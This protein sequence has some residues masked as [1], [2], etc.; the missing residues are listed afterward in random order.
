MAS[1]G[2]RSER[3][4]M[5]VP[6]I[7]KTDGTWAYL[8]LGPQGPQGIQ[9]IQ[10]PKGD[11][12]SIGPVGP[13][14]PPKAV[15][16][17]ALWGPAFPF[18]ETEVTQGLAG[19]G[20]GRCGSPGSA[21]SSQDLDQVAVLPGR[22]H[23]RCVGN[24][25]VQVR[26]LQRRHLPARCVPAPWSPADRRHQRGHDERDQV[27][28]PS[29]PTSRGWLLLDRA[30]PATTQPV[31]S[32]RSPRRRR[33]TPTCPGSTASQHRQLQRLAD[34]DLQQPG[35]QRPRHP[36]RASRVRSAAKGHDPQPAGCPAIWFRAEV[37]STR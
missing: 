29:P 5:T 34:H 27:R 18:Y 13:T 26:L 14:A 37:R 35:Q 28:R 22:H 12:G 17:S 3:H 20:S 25:T 30:G 16:K 15:V 31:R 1:S 11:T 23:T 8:A 9:G 19:T 2:Q 10:G 6:K 4:E 32:P 36:V 33:T 21:S 24:S 7:K